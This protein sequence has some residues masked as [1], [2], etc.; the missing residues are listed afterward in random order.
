MGFW[1]MMKDAVREGLEDAKRQQEDAKHR[2]SAELGYQLLMSTWSELFPVDSKYSYKVSQI[3]RELGNKRSS[4]MIRA[5][6][7]VGEPVTPKELYTVS[8]AYLDAGAS[9]RDKAIEYLEKY[10]SAGACWEGTPTGTQNDTGVKRDLRNTAIADVHF[11]LGKLY[12]AEYRF[13]DAMEQYRISAEICPYDADGIVG[14][15]GIYIKKGDYD[16][17]IRMFKDVLKSKYYRVYI[18]RGI[19]N[20]D[21]V[22]SIDRAYNNL[23]EKQQMGYVYHPRKKKASQPLVDT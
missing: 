16:G 1:D 17:G 19:E 23:L 4:L 2:E 15:S 3:K 20:T 21:F 14:M 5:A 8:H 12:E 7:L 11:S 10:I 18:Y 13:D 9:F 6:E 22:S